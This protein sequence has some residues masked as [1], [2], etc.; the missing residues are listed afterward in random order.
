MNARTLRRVRAGLS[1]SDAYWLRELHDAPLPVQV[2]VSRATAK[3]GE[4]LWQFG[5]DIDSQ[6]NTAA[7]MA[8]MGALHRFYVIN[9]LTP[10]QVLKAEAHAPDATGRG[11]LD[12]SPG[13]GPMGAGQPA[14]A[15]P[16]L[17]GTP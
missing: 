10:Q 14:A 1:E 7:R 13:G 11:G 16:A 12:A 5:I 15:G 8:L 4:L 6:Q 3:V 17:V 2:N 9:P